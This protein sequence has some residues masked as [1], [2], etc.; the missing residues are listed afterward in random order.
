MQH[1]PR[2]ATV[3]VWDSQKYLAD[4]YPS[5]AA[6]LRRCALWDTDGDGVIENSGSPDQ[7]FDSWVMTGPR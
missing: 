7:T 4:M 1:L 2:E 5:C 6:L 3:S